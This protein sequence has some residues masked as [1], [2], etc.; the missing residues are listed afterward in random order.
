MWSVGVMSGHIVVRTSR[1]VHRFEGNLHWTVTFMR[2]RVMKG[3]KQKKAHLV[4]STK[5]SKCIFSFVTV[6]K[7]PLQIIKK[8]EGN[9]CN[10]LE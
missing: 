7:H 5:I 8:T 4:S 2:I 3:L 9:F 6:L 1:V 10:D